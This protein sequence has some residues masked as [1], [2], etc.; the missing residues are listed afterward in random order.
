MR[1]TEKLIRQFVADHAGKNWRVKAGTDPRH[2]E[3]Y[4][5]LSHPTLDGLSADEFRYEA[6]I[7]CICVSVAG[8]TV[9]EHLALSTGLEPH[10]SCQC[11]YGMTHDGPDGVRCLN[12]NCRALLR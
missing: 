7:A 10:P 8:P 12:P 11:G 4:M 1:P 2:I 9:A 6:E 5:R 3:A